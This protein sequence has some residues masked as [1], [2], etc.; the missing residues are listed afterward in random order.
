MS[1]RS[2][3]AAACAGNE[4]HQELDV[5]RRRPECGDTV[6]SAFQAPATAAASATSPS[7]RRQIGDR[8]SLPDRS[9]LPLGSASNCGLTSNTM[10]APGTVNPTSASKTSPSEMNDRSPT[11][12]STDRPRRQRDDADVRALM[13]DDCGLATSDS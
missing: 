1:S 7:T 13:V 11:T 9:R 4:V 5:A 2:S 12:R 8:G 3:G 10:S 6:T